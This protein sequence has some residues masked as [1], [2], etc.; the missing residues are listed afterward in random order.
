MVLC[1]F[2]L[3][4]LLQYTRMDENTQPKKEADLNSEELYASLEQMM[5]SKKERD[6][7][8]K[9]HIRTYASDVA[10]QVKGKN[11]SVIQIALAEQKRQDQHLAVIKKSKTQK[12]VYIL[13][14]CIAFVGAFALVAWA[15]NYKD[16]TVAIP[17][18]TT[19]RANALVFSENQAVVNATNL[20]RSEFMQAFVSESSFVTQRGIT[21]IVPVTYATN[22]PRALSGEEF[23]SRFALNIPENL[24]VLFQDDFMFGY[25]QN[26]QDNFLILKFSDFDT[27]LSSMREW[28]DFLIQDFV[29][30][31]QIGPINNSEI[32]TKDFESEIILNK[33]SRVVRDT[34]QNIVFMYTFMDRQHIVLASKQETIQEI[35]SRFSVQA[36]Q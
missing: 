31:M 13:I 21:N 24:P 25:L 2:C 5:R 8:P 19:P 28:E 35:L 4:F 18:T 17:E 26:T 9:E 32:F 6:N 7:A 10:E 34:S 14:A 11:M 1:V 15:L 29:T 30:L 22:P 36:I 20:S 23:L 16:S 3:Y 27:V 12:I 33:A